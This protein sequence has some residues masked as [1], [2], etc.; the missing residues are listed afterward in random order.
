MPE[1]AS[2][3]DIAWNDE[4][5]IGRATTPGG[6]TYEWTQIFGIETLNT[7]EKTPD[8]IDVTHMQSPGRTRETI[9]GLLSAADWSQEKQYW[10]GDEGDILLEELAGL[11]EAGTKEDVLVEYNVAGIR[12]TYRG[13]VNAFT[14]S[15]SIG[16]K[17]MVSLSMKVFER[18]TPNPRT[19]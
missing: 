5:W 16:D 15:A 14:P 13:Y 18:V 7:P 9:P 11:T 8:D 3:A 12:R 6:S 10:P 1:R 19:P 17:R 2:Q 4:L